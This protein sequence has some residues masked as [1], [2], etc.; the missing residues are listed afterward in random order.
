MIGRRR[1]KTA[2][3]SWFDLQPPPPARSGS[4][5]WL[6]ARRRPRA[7]LDLVGDDRTHP[8]EDLE[9]AIARRG[10]RA[11]SAGISTSRTTS[12]RPLRPR[13]GICISVRVRGFGLTPLE[14]MAAGVPPLLLDTPVARESCGDAALYV[15]RRRRCRHGGRPGTD[16]GGPRPHVCVCSPRLPRR[17]PNINGRRPHAVHSSFSIEMAAAIDPAG[18]PGTIGRS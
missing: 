14:A 9:G 13:P 2:S 10:S 15:G 8:H 17:W 16:S 1:E 7:S 11:A 5:L 12:S 18:L 6:L 3:S 4:C